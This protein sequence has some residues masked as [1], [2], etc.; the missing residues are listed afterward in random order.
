AVLVG[1]IAKH[2]EP[3][4]ADKSDQDLSVD[5]VSIINSFLSRQ[6]ETPAPTVDSNPNE[7]DPKI[8]KGQKN[9]QE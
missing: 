6:I 8:D 5:D 1:L 2:I 3:L 4:H 7:T 9:D